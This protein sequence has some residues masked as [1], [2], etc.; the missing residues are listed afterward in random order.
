MIAFDV[1]VK[2]GQAIRR[3]N[4]APHTLDTSAALIM[5]Q[6][7]LP[8]TGTREARA[9]WEAVN[10]ADRDTIYAPGGAA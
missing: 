8:P 5:L 1:Q 2:V 10:E 4:R 3:L 9:V 6:S 7:A